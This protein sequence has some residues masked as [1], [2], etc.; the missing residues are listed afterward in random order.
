MFRLRSIALL[1]V[2]VASSGCARRIWF[3]QPLREGF[4]LGVV[5]SD[6]A[7]EADLAVP[8]R[9]PSEL[10][11]FV[12]GRITLEREVTSDQRGIENGRV[13]VRRGRS[14]HRVVI[15]RG[16][17]GI[18]VG[19]GP[20]WVAVSFEKG[21]QLI[22]DLV[23][24]GED[25]VGKDRAPASFGGVKMPSTYYRLRTTDDGN[26]RWVTLGETLYEA[27]D[28]STKARLKVKRRAWTQHH[29]S[30]RIMRGRRIK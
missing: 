2:M 16:T 9:A 27:V 26:G 24:R 13:V 15:R 30:R 19:W 8:G 11:Y 29:R 21:T 5:P 23:Q 6:D 17:P 4:E 14:V 1:L 7:G 28:G 3:T 20:D 22:F 25:D 12:S 10:Q 18:A